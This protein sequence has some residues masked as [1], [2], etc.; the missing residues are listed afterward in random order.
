MQKVGRFF[1]HTHAN[2][3]VDPELQTHETVCLKKLPP[4]M[5][6]AASDQAGAESERQLV[7][8][9]APDKGLGYP[10]IA[11]EVPTVFQKEGWSVLASWY[12]RRRG[13]ES[14]DS[15]RH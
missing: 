6:K 7:L 4:P 1:L 2:T 10:K 3:L 11:V 5:S 15:E 12:W 9:K 14:D 13:R 8:P